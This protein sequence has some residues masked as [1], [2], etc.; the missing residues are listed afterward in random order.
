MSE[1]MYRPGLEGVIAGETVL[2]KVEQTG[3]AYRGYSIEDLAENVTFEEVAHLLFYGELPTAKQLSQ[4]QT[5]LMQFR[6]L[7]EE[8]LQALPPTHSPPGDKVIAEARTGKRPVAQ[9]G[10]APVSKTGGW[11]F[12][13]LLACQASPPTT[14]TQGRMRYV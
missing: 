8:V 1:T 4:L 2:S 12:E 7:P 11:G 5:T 9:F 13:S 3:L 6:P 14:P 10:R